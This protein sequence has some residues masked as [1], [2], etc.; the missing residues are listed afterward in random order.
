VP[1]RTTLVS[2]LRGRC[3]TMSVVDLRAWIE[4]RRVTG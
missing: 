2:V 4:R 3:A 1:G